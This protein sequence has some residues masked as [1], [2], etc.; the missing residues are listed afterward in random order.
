MFVPIHK[1]LEDATKNYYRVKEGVYECRVYDVSLTDTCIVFTVAY[2][3]FNEGKINYLYIKYFIG[4]ASRL[5]TRATLIPIVEF[6]CNT[7]LRIDIS[8][9]D[10]VEECQRLKFIDDTMLI[11]VEKEGNYKNIRFVIKFIETDTK[12]TI[13]MFP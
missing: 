5:F 9:E 1:G 7:D 13:K 4:E 3:D 2:Y 10:L 11:K 8:I 12:D 6:Y